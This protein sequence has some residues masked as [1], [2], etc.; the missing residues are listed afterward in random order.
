MSLDK[1]REEF[2]KLKSCV[3]STNAS[4]E[5][6]KDF[7]SKK[8]VENAFGFGVLSPEERKRTYKRVA[9]NF[10]KFLL[11]DEKNIQI[12]EFM[13]EKN[14]ERI[15]EKYSEEIRHFID[16]AVGLQYGN[17]EIR[18][19]NSPAE[20]L[21]DTFKNIIE[22]CDFLNDYVEFQIYRKMIKAKYPVAKTILKLPVDIT[23]LPFKII[24]LKKT[25][26][27]ISNR[28]LGIYDVMEILPASLK[29]QISIIPKNIEKYA[30]EKNIE[31]ELL[32]Q[33]VSGH[34]DV[35]DRQI[36]FSEKLEAKRLEYIT[37]IMNIRY[38]EL[39]GGFEKYGY[40]NLTKKNC[41]LLRRSIGDEIQSM[42]CVL[43]GH[44]TF[45][46]EKAF[47]DN[48]DFL[49]KINMK[50]TGIKKIKKDLVERFY[51]FKKK[52]EQYEKGEAF[53]KHLYAEGGLESANNSLKDLPNGMYEIENPEVYLSRI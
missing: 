46:S 6:L 13:E 35:H 9:N 51:G 32:E 45:F 29:G 37:D 4:Y 52:R 42:M 5:M 1:T 8:Y 39:L 43:E 33:F 17:P 18:F 12:T 41:K 21:R 14:Q 26:K 53:I 28:I 22:R 11:P 3:K 36:V 27:Y 30:L 19:Y 20:C 25:M 2:E 49:E 16:N 50:K 48:K 44:A 40:K 7:T 23:I 24:R 38:V 34:E 47:A 31:P 15:T 10:T